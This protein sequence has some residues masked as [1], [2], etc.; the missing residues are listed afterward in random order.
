LFALGIAHL[1]NPRASRRDTAF[2]ILFLSAPV[3]GVVLTVLKRSRAAFWSVGIALAAI[4]LGCAVDQIV[5]GHWITG[6]GFLAVGAL[7]GF[8]WREGDRRRS[9]AP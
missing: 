4:L 3:A 2:G 7:T 6:L 8:V 5:G 9:A 1:V